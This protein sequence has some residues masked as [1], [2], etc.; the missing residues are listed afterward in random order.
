MER[1][2]KYKDS[3][4]EWIGEVPEHWEVKQFR[5]CMSILTDFTANGSFASLAANVN[6]LNAGY[7]R[8]VRLTDLRENLSNQG[9]Y[10]DEHAHKFLSKSELFGGEILLANVGAYAG[11]SLQMPKLDGV[12]TLG[13]NMFLIR[14]NQDSLFFNYMINANQFNSILSNIALSSAQP[15]L[16]KDD[17]KGLIIVLPPINEQA[18]ITSYLDRKT[19]EINQFIADKKRLITLYEEEKTALINQAVTKGINPE[20][21]MK[22]SGIEW[23][24]E[25]PEHWEVKKLKYI[26]QS[27]VGGG[28]PSTANSMYW[29]GDIPWVSA[30]DM[31]QD[32]I[33]STQDFITELAIKESSTSFISD[34]RVLIVVRSGILKHTLPVAINKVPVCINQDLK[35]L[36]PI[37]QISNDYFFWK[38]KGMSKD[39]LTFCN[40]MGA[41]VDSIELTDLM[42]FPFSFPNIQEQHVIVNHI[43]MGLN[44]I[45]DK[46]QKHQKLIDLLSE[47]RTALISEVVTGKVRVA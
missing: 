40:K 15:K 36:K 32:L 2:E 44:L 23:L 27:I 28:T 14:V 33:F 22:D 46:L 42:N 10:V 9:I 38:L 5:H 3:G 13:P 29:D 17:I 25:V 43:K 7:S 34:E 21:K 16:N 45:N 24:G 35:A 31:K 20:V 30:K 6:Y 19:T 4:V 18:T 37:P 12:F 47:Y 11:L 1:Y 41:T 39:I 8:L 26:L